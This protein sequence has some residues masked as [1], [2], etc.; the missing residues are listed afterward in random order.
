L[1]GGLETILFT[2]KQKKELLE[3]DQHQYETN[4]CA[5]VINMLC[6]LVHTGNQMYQTYKHVREIYNYAKEFDKAMTTITRILIFNN[7]NIDDIH[8]H[9]YLIE[10]M[11]YHMARQMNQLNGYSKEGINIGGMNDVGHIYDDLYNN[12]QK[13]ELGQEI[14]NYKV[15]C[16]MLNQEEKGGKQKQLQL[17][18]FQRY[19]EYQKVGQ[20]FI[21]T[22]IFDEPLEKEDKRKQGNNSIYVKYIE[23]ILLH[24]LSKQ[25]N[26]TCILRKNQIWFLL[27][28]INNKYGTI[29]NKE[30]EELDYCTNAFAV[31]HF[32]QRCNQ[33]L[34]RILFSALNNLKNRKLLSYFEQVIIVPIEGSGF[35]ASDNDIRR[36]DAV[37]RSVLESMGFQSM[38]QVYCKFKSREFYDEVNYR[39]MELYDW[40]YSF[41]Q[42]KLIY[43]PENIIKAIPESEIQLQKLTLNEQIIDTI[44]NGAV[45]LLEKNDKKWNEAYERAKDEWLAFGV[46]EPH[47]PNNLVVDDNGKKVFHYPPYY[48]EAQRLLADELLRIGNKKPTDLMTSDE[49]LDRELDELFACMK[50]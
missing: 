17:V 30:L 39:L 45:M 23:V 10:S 16:Q 29:S 15:L 40:K 11:I 2:D 13:F 24:Y 49:Q 27:G 33:R 14:K 7:E 3:A 28:M 44:N 12:A 25:K 22:D 42:Y 8:K 1:G 41:K 5:Q 43:T 50:S 48:L 20:K 36:L 37:S 46:G 21:I 19:F 6:G 34:E 35:I 31:N 38:I 18:D 32:Y 47:I 9:T 4:D 26:Y